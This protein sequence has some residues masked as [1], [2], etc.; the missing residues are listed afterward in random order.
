MSG[1][2]AARVP[3]LMWFDTGPRPWDSSDCSSMLNVLCACSCQ[4]DGSSSLLAEARLSL[5]WS[6]TTP[7]GWIRELQDWSKDVAPKCWELKGLSSYQAID[8]FI[9]KN[10]STRSDA[11]GLNCRFYSTIL[12]VQVWPLACGLLTVHLKEYSKL[13][14]TGE[15]LDVALAV[16]LW[17]ACGGSIIRWVFNAFQLFLVSPTTEVWVY[18]RVPS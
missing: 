18:P 8:F 7:R 4:M 14:L 15:C 12:C 3:V 10:F 13:E 6:P 9:S 5:M 1:S 2:S 16:Y 11:C 17:C